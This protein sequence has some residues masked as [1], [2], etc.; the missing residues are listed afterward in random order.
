M[1]P[2]AD[3]PEDSEYITLAASTRV[4][5]DGSKDPDTCSGF[6]LSRTLVARGGYQ[7]WCS[8]LR[9]CGRTVHLHLLLESMCCFCTGVSDNCVFDGP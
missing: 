7:S 6:K 9:T 3:E 5:N 2:D 4:S 8:D 1:P